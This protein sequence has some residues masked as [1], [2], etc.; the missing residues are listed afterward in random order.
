M[1]LR[2]L[3]LRRALVFVFCFSLVFGP[4]ASYAQDAAKPAPDTRVRKANYD[5]ASRWTTAK[6]TK[7]VFDTAVQPHWLE[8]GERFW[9]SYETSQGKKWWLV[10]PTKK[11][12]TPLFDNA[13]MA[14]LLT[15]LTHIPYDAQHLPIQTLKFAKNDSV[16]QFDATVPRDAD[17]PGLKKEDATTVSGQGGNGNNRP[18]DQIDDPQQRRQQQG[19]GPTPSP[20]PRTR[21]CGGLLRRGRASSSSERHHWAKQRPRSGW[22]TG[23]TSRWST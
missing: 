16:F 23:P 9:Y 5:L 3:C 6:V 11:A 1:Q 21:S 15:N 19:A 13:K 22:T 20:T 18:E 4:T 17:I 14:A 7:L 10:D 12:K 8:S 2:Q